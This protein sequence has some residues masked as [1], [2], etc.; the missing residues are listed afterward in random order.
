MRLTTYQEIGYVHA[1]LGRAWGRLH[2]IGETIDGDLTTLV[3][4]MNGVEELGRHPCH[5]GMTYTQR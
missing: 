4:S 1:C 5:D 3:A 2:C